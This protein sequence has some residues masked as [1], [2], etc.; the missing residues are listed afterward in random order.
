MVFPMLVLTAQTS[1]PTPPS[2]SSEE[3]AAHHC[4]SPSVAAGFDLLPRLVEAKHSQ[5]LR[6]TNIKRPQKRGSFR[7]YRG[8]LT[9]AML[10]LSRLANALAPGSARLFSAAAAGENSFKVCR[11][12]QCKNQ[13]LTFSL[14]QQKRQHCHMDTFSSQVPLAHREDANRSNDHP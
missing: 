7:S 1:H 9:V 2:W 3:A 8:L 5:R 12:A 11:R 14:A 4:P 13:R 6:S 10:S